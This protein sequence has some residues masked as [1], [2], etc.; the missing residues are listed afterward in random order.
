MA[1]A[2][3]SPGARGQGESLHHRVGD[4]RDQGEVAGA[5][6]PINFTDQKAVDRAGRDDGIGLHF[7]DDVPQR[8]AQAGQPVDLALDDLRG[9]EQL[10][11]AVP[12][13]RRAADRG[14]EGVAE[15]IVEPA[16]ARI[17]QIEHL[18]ARA[19]TREAF[20]GVAHVPCGDVFPLS[21][22]CGEDKNIF[23]KP[24]RFVPAT[25]VNNL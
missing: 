14:L 4:E 16:V 13:F 11:K 23:Q 15:Q 3:K 12:E 1:T 2:K 6:V 5:P 25:H 8:I 10:V 17:E 19:V 18:D 21:K 22:T 20:D 24:V 7:P 9:A